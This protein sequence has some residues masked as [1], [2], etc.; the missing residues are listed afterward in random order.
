MSG[1]AAPQCNYPGC[2]KPTWNPEGMCHVHLGATVPAHNENIDRMSARATPPLSGTTSGSPDN[3]HSQA[4]AAFPDMGS[5]VH[6]QAIREQSIIALR[7]AVSVDVYRRFPQTD[8]EDSES[9]MGALKQYHHELV[10]RAHI[11]PQDIDDEA[12]VSMSYSYEDEYG[13]GFDESVNL[14]SYGVLK[15]WELAR[16]MGVKQD[17]DGAEYGDSYSDYCNEVAR[18]MD[19]AVSDEYMRQ[20]IRY[21]RIIEEVSDRKPRCS[22]PIFPDQRVEF[23]PLPPESAPR[24]KAQGQ[25]PPQ[26]PVA[27]KVASSTGDTLRRAGD[28]ALRF[29]SDRVQQYNEDK[30]L[31]QERARQARRERDE[32]TRRREEDELRRYQL[33]EA[34]KSRGWWG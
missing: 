15:E 34:R 19:N 4:S 5:E 1:Y 22:D 24:I 16:S 30:P 10:E 8:L 9:R 12:A 32:R 21:P 23:E 27:S 14:A 3:I 7:S 2:T 28:G 13:R 29:I 20:L 25:G 6:P 18:K 17:E 31:R 33:K 26:R 11:I